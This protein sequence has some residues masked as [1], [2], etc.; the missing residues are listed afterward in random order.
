MAVQAK[1]ITVSVTLVAT[2]IVAMG[3]TI[4]TLF[5]DNNEAAVAQIQAEVNAPTT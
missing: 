4:F 3:S 1:N 5:R 2:I